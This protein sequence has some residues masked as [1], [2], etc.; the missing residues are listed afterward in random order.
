[1]LS[2]S[3]KEISAAIEEGREKDKEILE[4]VTATGVRVEGL[5]D[6]VSDLSTEQTKLSISINGDVTTGTP[7]I[8]GT[9]AKQD[10][11]LDYLKT[12]LDRVKRRDLARDKVEKLDGKLRDT[13][14]ERDEWDE[15]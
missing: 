4:H 6:K 10:R 3:N 1:M 15:P 5:T 14:L 11:K 9:L 2:G 13:P 8:R 7:G 12:E